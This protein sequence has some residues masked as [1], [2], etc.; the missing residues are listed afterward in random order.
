MNASDKSSRFWASCASSQEPWPSQ[1]PAQQAHKA[2]SHQMQ[3]ALLG[4]DSRGRL[5]RRPHLREGHQARASGG[6]LSSSM[7]RSMS[8]SCTRKRASQKKEEEELRSNQLP[9]RKIHYSKNIYM[10]DWGAISPVNNECSVRTSASVKGSIGCGGS[11]CTARGSGRVRFPTSM[12]VFTTP[13][14]RR[15]SHPE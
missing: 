9:M 2:S 10:V 1:G 8:A 4:E 13:R 12:R 6:T 15:V 3:L 11:P 5:R 14:L 7:K